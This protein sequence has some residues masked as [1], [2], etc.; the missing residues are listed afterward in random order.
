MLDLSLDPS[1]MGLLPELGRESDGE[2]PFW[3]DF[4]LA[5]FASKSLRNCSL[6]M[7]R[8]VVPA[9][10]C[11]RMMFSLEARGFSGVALCWG[12]RLVRPVLA[13]LG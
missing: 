2:V 7:L 3:S 9:R 5:A 4:D 6:F 11:W 10:S 1:A 12:C 13:Q 8:D